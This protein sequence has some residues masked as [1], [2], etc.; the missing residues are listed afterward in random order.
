MKTLTLHISDN[1]YDDVKRFLSLFSSNKIEIK[2]NISSLSK[3]TAKFTYREFEKKWAGLL[4]N[5][6][7]G[8]SWKDERIDYLYKKHL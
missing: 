6:E 3:N 8:E 2:E 7:I 4:Q 1:I 5:Y